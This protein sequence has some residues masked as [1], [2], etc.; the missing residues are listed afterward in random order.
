MDVLIKGL[1]NNKLETGVYWKPTTS[2]IFNNWKAHA[3]TEWKI[4]TL[5]NLIKQGKLI[6]SD[7]SLVNKEMKYLTK[8]FH[9]INDFPISIMNTIMQI[10]KVK[11]EE[12][13]LMKFPIK[14]N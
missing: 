13:E 14:F 10:V 9:E 7:Q 6:C 11:I 5:G 4:G 12:Q 2:D 1:N 8:V 3:A